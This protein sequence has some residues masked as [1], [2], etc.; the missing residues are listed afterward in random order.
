MQ[1]QGLDAEGRMTDPHHSALL[2]VDLQPDFLP[3]G[4][5]AIPR[6]REIIPAIRHA[7]KRELFTM[8]VATQDWHPMGHVSF[9]SSYPD[10]KPF[11]TIE[12][13]G[14]EQT[15]WPDHCVQGTDGAELEP[16]LPWYRVSAVIRKGTDPQSDSYS[17]FR[18]NWDPRGRRPPTGLV[19]YLKECGITDCYVCGLARDVCAK[20][21]AEDSC[22]AGFRTW[23]LWDLTRAVDPASDEQVRQDLLAGGVRVV[24]SDQLP[25]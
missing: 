2:V 17:A 25:R 22:H 20:W 10:R 23:F 1:E 9:G 24:T 4:S 7:M 8:V 3:G 21:T 11:D 13:N 14:Y 6:G 16:G 5:L 18:N 19:G 12:V 15:L